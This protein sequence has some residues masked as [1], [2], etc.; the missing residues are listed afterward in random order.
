MC[1]SHSIGIHH[2]IFNGGTVGRRLV[3]TLSIALV[4]T[5]LGSA[6]VSA[7]SSALTSPDAT[8]KSATTSTP[9]C[10]PVVTRSGP[11][12]YVA[13]RYFGDPN[14]FGTNVNAT[15][16]WTVPVGVTSMD[17]LVVGGGGGGGTLFGGGGGGGGVV[18]TR[19]TV[20]EGD[21]LTVTIGAGGAGG[22]GSTYLTLNSGTNG[23]DS[24]ITGNGISLVA[25]GGGG[26][27]RGGKDAP[28][29]NVGGSGGGGS[30]VQGSIV[31]GGKQTLGAQGTAGQGNAGGNGS[32][33]GSGGYWHYTGGGGG[34]AAAAGNP[35]TV[36]G[37]N[38]GNGK[39]IAWLPG[40]IATS[41]VQVGQVSGGS[42]YFG[43]GGGGGTSFPPGIGDA[44]RI[45]GGL[46]GG[47][48]GGAGPNSVQAFSG[49]FNTGGGGGGAGIGSYPGTAYEPPVA[50]YSSSGG[51]GGSGV[52][53]FRYA[54]AT[55][56]ALTLNGST[57]SATATSTA[58]D[59]LT[60]SVTVSAWVK[61]DTVPTTGEQY[62][63][64]K[65]GAFALA[66]YNGRWDAVV[67][68][69]SQA[70]FVLGETA[71]VGWTHVALT[72]V[73]SGTL[74]LYVNG[75]LSA[76]G[77][78]SI[79]AMSTD[80]DTV[81]VGGPHT[82]S[83]I[84]M[85]EVR[86]WSTARSQAQIQADMHT[87]GP[88][89]A[90]GLV[91]Y[92]DFNTGYGSTVFNNKTGAAA[93]THLTVSG[94]PEWNDVKT[95]AT[96]NGATVLTFPRSYLTYRGGWV[97]PEGVSSVRSLIVG[98]GGGAGSGGGGG[99]GFLETT[100]SVTPND[101]VTVTVGVGGL[102]SPGQTERGRDGGTSRFGDLQ[103][104][105]GGGGGRGMDTTAGTGGAHG[106][107]APGVAAPVFARGSGGGATAST[108]SAA[109][110][111]TGT[112]QGG[113]KVSNTDAP[114]GGGG[115]AAG[116]GKDSSQGGGGGAGETSTISGTQLTYAPGGRAASS[117]QL[118]PLASAAGSGGNAAIAGVTDSG[119]AG[120]VIVRYQTYFLTIEAGDAQTVAAG[121]VV[122]VNPRVLV[123]FDNGS[124]ASGVE[125]TFARPNTADSATVG[126]DTRTTDASGY[127]ETTW[128]LGPDGGAYTLTASIVGMTE[129]FTATA[130]GSVP[131]TATDGK[132]AQRVGSTTGVAVTSEGAACVI[133]FKQGTN[134]WFV[135]DG[136]TAVQYIVVGGGGAGGVRHGG[137]G[138][139][140]GLLQGT[141]VVTPGAPIDVSVG[142]GGTGGVGRSNDSV[143]FGA[144]PT[145][146][147]NSTVGSI[148][149]VGGGAG[150]GGN[151]VS[152]TQD[153]GSGGGAASTANGGT[154]TA[155]QGNNGGRGNGDDNCGYYWCGGGGGG[156]GAAGA[157][158]GGGAGSGGAGLDVSSVLSV[159]AANALGVGDTSTANAVYFAGGG[160]GGTYLGKGSQ[161]GGLGGGG[162]GG[163]NAVALSGQA[164]TGGGGGGGRYDGGW[165]GDSA[166]GGSGVV[167]IRYVQ[168]QMT[169]VSGNNQSASKGT[170]LSQ[171][172]KVRITNSAGAGVFDA[173]VTFTVTGGGGS[174]ESVTVRTDGSG[175]AQTTWTLGDFVGTHTLVASADAT[176]VDPVTF[177]A[178]TTQIACDVRFE[179]LNFDYAKAVNKV[180]TGKVKGDKVLFREVLPG[181]RCSG[182]DALVTTETITNAKIV[183][184]EAGARAGGDNSFF[185]ADVDITASN[186]FAEFSFSFYESGTYGTGNPKPV[187][188]QNVKVTAID[189]DA[190]Q[191]N[192]LSNFN[193]YTLASTTR[194]T[195]N[196]KPSAFPA[197][198]R[199]QG[200]A[201]SD[202]NSPRDQVVVT[203]AQVD[204]FSVKFGRSTSGSP[205]YFGVAFKEL[206][207][208][209]TTPQTVGTEYTLTY[210]A[211]GGTGTGPTAVTA[212]AGTVVNVATNSFTRSGHVFLGWN[213]AADGAGTAFS[214]GMQFS[215]P[216]NGATLYAQ[217]SPVTYTITYNGNGAESGTVPASGTS[218]A[219]VVT[220]V[221][222]N[223][224]TLERTGY[225]LSGWS[226]DPAGSTTY[227]LGSGTFTMPG[228]N[229]TLYALWSPESRAITYQDNRPGGCTS[230]SGAVP[231]DPVSASVGSSVTIPGN[232]GTLTCGGYVFTGWNTAANG[233]GT[234]YPP[235]STVTMGDGGLT[236]YAQWEQLFYLTYN[237]NGGSGAPASTP[238]TSGSTVSVASGGSVQRTG[239]TFGG[240][241]T[242][243]DGSGTVLGATYRMPADNVTVYA[244][245]TADEQVI[246]YNA[247]GGSG[248]P[249][250]E[251]SSTGASYTIADGVP[252]LTG[253][254]FV[255]WN[256]T[257]DGSGV[258][259]VAGDPFQVPATDVVLYAQWTPVPYALT[260]SANGAETGTVPS[261]LVRFVGEATTVSTT[262]LALAGYS[263]TGW[264]TAADGSG[265]HYSASTVLTMPAADV[266]L[267]AQWSANPYRVLFQPNG[268]QSGSVPNTVTARTDST[269]NVPGNPG[270]LTR[271]GYTFA[272]WALTPT[273]EGGL[274][275]GGSFVMPAN[276]VVLYAQWA[277][278]TYTLTYDANGGTSAP[279]AVT[280]ATNSAV[281]IAAEGAMTRNGY[282]FSGWAT[283]TTGG[284]EVAVGSSYTM[285]ASN[286]TLYAMWVA[287]DFNVTYNANGGQGGPTSE[288]A[289]VGTKVPTGNPTAP[290]RDGYTFGGWKFT[291]D[292]GTGAA[293]ISMPA[294]NT[295]LYA[296]WVPAPAVLTYYYETGT[297]AGRSDT[298]TVGT[299]TF[300]TVT[301][302]SDQP[303][304]E[305]FT[306]MGWTTEAD[307]TG[308]G[309][310]AGDEFTIPIG[311]GK[312]YA[313]WLPIQYVLAYDPNGGEHAPDPVAAIFQESVT[314]STADPGRAGYTFAGWTTT[315]DSPTTSVSSPYGMPA[316]DI[317]LFAQWTPIPYTLSYNAN[318]GSGVLPSNAPGQFVDQ[319]VTLD[320]V[321]VPTRTGYT[322]IGWTTSATGA[323]SMFAPGGD[324][325]MPASDVTLYAQ[326][327][328]NSYGVEFDAN[329]G[330]G[331]P[332]GFDALAGLDVTIP[333]MAPSRTDYTFRFWRDAL[334]GERVDPNA[335]FAMPD[336]VLRLVAQWE[337]TPPPA[338]RPVVPPAPPEGPVTPQPPVEP[339]KPVL[340]PLLQPTV[341]TTTSGSTVT[342]TP[343]SDE[344]FRQG[345]VR[346]INPKT[347]K[348]V[349]KLTTAQGTFRVNTATGQVTFTPK[350]GFTGIAQ[351]P[352]RAVTTDGQEQRST[353]TVV[354]QPGEAQAI[355]SISRTV[356]FA[357]MSS[358]LDATDRRILRNLV[359]LVNSRGTET[360]GLVVGFVQ[361][362]GGVY[363]DF[364]LSTARARSVK[365]FLESLGVKTIRTANGLGRAKESDGKA[366]RA[367]VTLYYVPSGS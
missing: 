364:T 295:V 72:W 30:Y 59:A 79:S 106:A 107:D 120:V 289:T 36:G 90:A 316:S 57:E 338:P 319:I 352:V 20:T 70:A 218:L 236:L 129:T 272:G 260:Y 77:T 216:L 238:G 259:Y 252:T 128:T 188:L 335:V 190:Y 164:N 132:C 353:V 47:A 215:M 115:G 213:T 140:G 133:A 206:G 306:F 14:K 184:Y 60:T 142:A 321:T 170:V 256:T 243:A 31:S 63:V 194:L 110:G 21:Q 125:V 49:A 56:F 118:Q 141:Q 250:P 16:N 203:Y 136:V 162:R 327:V 119:Q 109:Y 48:R 220:T 270:A 169:L 336:R 82:Q 249:L 87:Y 325:V 101:T 121:T 43:G 11:Y 64:Y 35:G 40:S 80:T 65:Q 285:P 22:T 328:G 94:V 73:K 232:S 173:E 274:V 300:D 257:A 187:I 166:A 366:R 240:W 113:A 5:L 150:L 178:T 233:S 13:I 326:W 186:G 244:I 156:A 241:N 320:S 341:G 38:G 202:S 367:T 265:T 313:Q 365:A 198:A 78:T 89:D 283:Q 6:P 91:A 322:F 276:D 337:Y 305:G 344:R 191:F 248:A 207:W 46:G 282:W 137:G 293:T 88:V 151:T 37:T 347:G 294:G 254:T 290:T 280:A 217:W 200:P 24:S 228:N 210:N 52:V 165:S 281:L 279:A 96:A 154:G 114:G 112:H 342:I 246:S 50:A 348:T 307:G 126:H 153:G 261:S 34:G 45:S 308:F 161:P 222:S 139:A 17:V 339:V 208:G 138:G 55:D 53:V 148:T 1:S 359:R 39:A 18:D 111:G 105:G 343:L 62:M 97:I 67:A 234:D 158:A 288:S 266:L 211:N 277:A 268:A 99:G 175:Y 278:N 340:P 309:F 362:V 193:S 26:G 297:L 318:G 85:D 302:M 251:A 163:A 231:T 155:G 104:G 269:V 100:T 197:S 286:V 360:K 42:T 212:A 315:V 86:I 363:N 93:D 192:D 271:P 127:A 235:G 144:A 131:I 349:T 76:T 204:V 334:T 147:G 355:R 98:G 123:R 12:T 324:F 273:D 361:P 267:Y 219:G 330:T 329:G 32:R 75:Q 117:T 301:V 263:F 10:R 357:S 122:P 143:A 205:N 28:N 346:L 124:P 258:A 92:Y 95:A 41:L 2:S 229:V 135:P 9:M 177:T 237:A 176:G 157:N 333:G 345:S 66:I 225:T 247:N 54:P 354:I 27:A 312:L 182:V 223:P 287:T 33:W 25:K 275:N 3:A 130:I 15:C 152:G 214:A 116:P 185:Q 44:N 8:I 227:A 146:G 168:T 196:P 221:A 181:S 172:V 350:R 81:S 314:L 262:N 23:A 149:A 230:T 159:A 171:P 145:K 298:S 167:V 71:T 310:R 224:G 183:N 242:A 284:T 311:G 304:R 199:F 264:N 174:V 29:G 201:G 351:A 299:N 296:H 134:Q 51:N 323:L 195:V 4:A 239:Y 7:V 19:T 253:Y 331:G 180:G 84:V 102:R 160:G 332:A 103:A 291:P 74:S 303:T 69:G 317:T 255:S 209:S 179:E 83:T 226:P 245:W 108:V 61:L 68:D 358:R 356:Y 58:F 292:G 189:I